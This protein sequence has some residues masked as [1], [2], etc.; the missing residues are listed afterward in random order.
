MGEFK[1]PETREAEAMI[2]KAVSIMKA[3]GRIEESELGIL[4]GI[5][6]R[7]GIDEATAESILEDPDDVESSHPGDPFKRA[8]FIV[9]MASAV[10]ADGHADESEQH[11]LSEIGKSLDYTSEQI[12]TATEAVASAMEGGEGEFDPALIAVKVASAFS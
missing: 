5:T 8:L 9:F 11:L 7:L 4:R 10:W 3:D 12:K 2:A 6:S 1:S